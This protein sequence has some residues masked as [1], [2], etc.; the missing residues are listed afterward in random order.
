MGD[1]TTHDI[2]YMPEV[3]ET[4]EDGLT[5]WETALEV[6]DNMIYGVFE[7]HT[8]SHTLT[9]IESG[10]VHSNLGASGTITLTLP[11]D[12]T[13]GC[14]FNFV[15][16][17]AFELRIDPGAAGAIYLG[18]TKGTDDYYIYADA[19]N[20]SVTVVNIGSGDWAA[21][22]VVGTWGKQT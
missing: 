6:A 14:M 5:N 4:P 9:D 10:S 2:F 22:N 19:V 20:E 3:E 7:A 11:Q 21:M 18:G 12:A 13:V 1:Y 8:T 17:A 16:L 15:V